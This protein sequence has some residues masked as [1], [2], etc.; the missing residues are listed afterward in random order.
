[1]SGRNQ[2]G[3]ARDAQALSR[4]IE[5]LRRGAEQSEQSDLLIADPRRLFLRSANGTWFRLVVDDAGA[6]STVNVGA[7]PI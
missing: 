4:S 7:E 6:L 1:M 5:R 3:A 2:P